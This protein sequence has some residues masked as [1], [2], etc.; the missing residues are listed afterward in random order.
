MNP[1][2]IGNSQ[3]KGQLRLNWPDGR[4]QRLDHAELRRQCPCSRCRAFRL[5]GLTVQVDPRV[6]VVEINAQGYGVQLVFSDG[7][8]RGIFPWAYLAG[9]EH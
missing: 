9:L 6:R 7:H 5:Q 1:L 4:E 2:A 3:V 8:E